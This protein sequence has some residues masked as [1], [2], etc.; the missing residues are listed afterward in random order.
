MANTLLTINMITREAIRLWKNTNAFLQ[1]IDCQYD[2][3][4]AQTGAKIGDS[5]RIRLPNDYTVRTGPAAQVQDTAEQ[6]TTLTLATQKGVDVSFNSHERTMSLDDYSERVLAPAVNNLAGNIAADI[7]SGVEGGVSNMVANQDGAFNIISP[8]SLQFLDAGA[9]MDLQSAPKG[10]RKVVNDPRSQ[11]RIV[12]SLTG[13]FNPATIVSK[14]FT[15][16]EMYNALGLTWMSDQTVIIHTNGALAQSSATVNGANQTGLNLVVNALANGLNQG[17]IVTAAG[18]NRVNRITKKDTGELMQF[19]VT[20]PVLAGA[21]SIPIYPALIPAV[22]GN[23]VQYQTV[24]ASPANGAAVNPALSLA[25]SAQYR[26]NIVFTPEA[27]T[28]ATADMELP[29]GVHEAYRENFD[30]ISIRMITAYDV[31][32]DQLITRLDVLYGFLYIRPE[33]CVAVADAV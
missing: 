30:G 22:G 2:D 12:N 15:T 20:A 3:Q 21:T 31:M 17:D 10:R 4:F 28:M 33:W 25:A 24:T 8:T 16:G 18:V 14:Q 29:R 26:K 9:T 1:E 6:S 5:L 23:P 32:S 19:V 27:I 11:A 13:L 7:M